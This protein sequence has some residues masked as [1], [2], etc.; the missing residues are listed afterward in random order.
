MEK[1]FLSNKL[2]ILADTL[3]ENFFNEKN[4]DKKIIVV[5]SLY[6]K[7]WL[8]KRFSDQKKIC[9]NVSFLSQKQ[10]LSFL[11]QKQ[12][13]FP[14]YQQLF[15]E[16]KQK[17]N[18][19]ITLSDNK[20]LDL[21]DAL[22]KLFFQCAF[23]EE[24]YN[25][26]EIWQK[27]LFEKIFL[28][29]RWLLPRNC[30]VEKLPQVELHFFQ[31]SD[32]LPICHYLIQ[33]Q[34]NVFHYDLSFCRYF[35]TDS[36]S[37]FERSQKL[38]FWRRKQ[39]SQFKLEELENYLRDNNPLLANFG[40]LKRRH[41]FLLEERNVE[42]YEHYTDIEAISFLGK[43]KGDIFN[44]SN[45]QQQVISQD[46]SFEIH[47]ATSKLRE[48]EILLDYIANHNDN[49]DEFCVLVSDIE[50]YAPFIHKTFKEA[51]IPYHI[52]TEKNDEVISGVL[53]LLDLLT[54]KWEKE[55]L[56]A[57]LNNKKFQKK[58]ELTSSD[59]LILQQWIEEANIRWGIDALQ[60]K[61]L[62]EKEQTQDNIDLNT[63]EHGLK[64]IM[65]G[66]A[67][68]NNDSLSYGVPNLDLADNDLFIKF[69]KI[70]NAL[71]QAISIL[72]EEYKPLSEWADTIFQ[73]SSTFFD[74]DEITEFICELKENNKLFT[75]KNFS[76]KDIVFLLKKQTSKRTIISNNGVFFS[77]FSNGAL[78]EKKYYCLIGMNHDFPKENFNSLNALNTYG[79]TKE[80]IQNIFLSSLFLADYLYISYVGITE[81]NVKM[82]PSCVIEKFLS[83]LND[84]YQINE[85]KISS[86]EKIHPPCRYHHSYFTEM[87]NSFSSHT[88]KVALSQYEQKTKEEKNPLP[89]ISDIP[90][91]ID[92]GDLISFAK[93]PLK[94]HLKKAYDIYLEPYQK[95]EI[96]FHLSYLYNYIAKKKALKMSS[97]EHDLVGIIEKQGAFPD[98]FWRE[99]AK[100]KL[101]RQLKTIKHD[102]QLLFDLS[103]HP[104][105]ASFKKD[106]DHLYSTPPVTITLDN[107]EIKIIGVLENI[108]DIGLLCLNN[109]NWQNLLKLWP[110]MLLFFNTK[111]LSFVPPQLF[112]CETK[113]KKCAFF[114]DMK[115]HLE[116]Y[117]AYFLKSHT[118][119]PI[120][121]NQWTEYIIEEK[122]NPPDI[123]K[124]RFL[125]FA[126][127]SINWQEIL[128]EGNSTFKNIFLPLAEEF[129]WHV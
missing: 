76:L 78:L 71:K 93:D 27:T 98:G 88:Y 47:C 5:P 80:E 49:I 65:W 111:E 86:I 6:I 34:N 127:S 48:V 72:S 89:M 33:Y 40:T 67:T 57:V 83:Y 17:I 59:I 23:L 121:I 25:N 84:C 21:T 122:P 74:I 77:S 123:E 117:I 19:Y 85:R 24:D 97:N 9:L 99:I 56:F 90:T 115:K 16:I 53:S 22:T 101:I 43:I 54:S 119:M 79:K 39:V 107:K 60:K 106:N 104:T 75:D 110:Q 124:D 38:N 73:L 12:L 105:C 7:R 108:S 26:L 30:K 113:E 95:E 66:I 13:P 32:L 8:M 42:S 3:E 94:F 52:N 102:K 82:P 109:F 62:L 116:N 29:E 44:F 81:E 126:F 15:L 20:L 128:K 4:Y 64:R 129:N 28:T 68:I 37:D 55:K 96:Q 112:F 63:W 120:L 2:S 35:W 103:F 87:K 118:T 69:L 114:S 11:F 61:N 70:F 31:I 10:L 92:I 50:T 58:Q 46:D 91:F 51:D 36:C 125:S 100:K 1:L 18:T 45:P 14:S 41:L